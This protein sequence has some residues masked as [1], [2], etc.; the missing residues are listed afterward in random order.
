MDRA[1]LKTALEPFL[2][3]CASKGRPL[4]DICFEEAFPGDSTT[5]FFVQVKAPW[6]DELSCSAALD[7]LFEVLWETTSVEIRKKVF[8]IQILDSSDQLHCTSEAAIN[9]AS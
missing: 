7:F 9:K 8:C 1:T 5:S 2:E 4:V 3:K 6:I